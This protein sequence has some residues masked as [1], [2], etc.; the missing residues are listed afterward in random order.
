[1]NN[2]I[3]F[4]HK[5]EEKNMKR[6]LMSVLAGLIMASFAACKDYKKSE[7]KGKDIS[8]SVEGTTQNKSYDEAE[9]EPEKKQNSTKNYDISVD[10]EN[11]TDDVLIT[12]AESTETEASTT[13]SEK[14]KGELPVIDD[15]NAASAHNNS[16]T[17]TAVNK[18]ENEGTTTTA[19][20]AP[21]VTDPDGVIELPFIPIEDLQ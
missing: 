2:E 15:D 10:I 16:I 11:I 21:I 17:T 8:V 14:D 20:D 12:S 18:S 19:N 5:Q 6:I 1:M 3:N 4:Y 7:S 9:S 13:T